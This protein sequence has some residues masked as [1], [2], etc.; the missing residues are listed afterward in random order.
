M[1]LHG[2]TSVVSLEILGTSSSSFKRLRRLFS[3]FVFMMILK[4]RA[5]LPAQVGAHGFKIGAIKDA[6]YY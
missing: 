3:Y 6:N 5:Y 1:K 2:L 4:P